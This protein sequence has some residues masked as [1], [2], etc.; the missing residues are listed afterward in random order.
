MNLTRVELTRLASRRFLRLLP[1]LVLAVLVMT[2]YG[3]ASPDRRP[4]PPWSATT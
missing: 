4:R 3:T 2:W 1:L